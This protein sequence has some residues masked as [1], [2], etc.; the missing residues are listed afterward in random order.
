MKRTGLC[1]LLLS[2]LLAPGCAGGDPG[3]PAAGSIS[4]GPK[5]EAGPKSSP[6]SGIPASPA[7]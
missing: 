6:K 3:Q 2:A 4:V 7:R 5:S 1:L